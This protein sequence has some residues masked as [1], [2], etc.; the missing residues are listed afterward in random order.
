[1]IAK[2][3]T[4]APEDAMSDDDHPKVHT[5]AEWQPPN[6]DDP[7][8]YFDETRVLPE[9]VIGT[10]VDGGEWLYYAA[11]ICSFANI[12]HYKIEQ[13]HDGGILRTNRA[14]VKFLAKG[15]HTQVIVYTGPGAYEGFIDM[16]HQ[17]ET[18]SD[19]VRTMRHAA[20]GLTAE[21]VINRYYRSRAAG[22]KVTLQQLADEHGFNRSYLRAAK[23]EYDKAGKWGSKKKNVR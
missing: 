3:L 16:L 12:Q 6:P 10:Y 23:M 8:Y 4:R 21:E 5:A 20:S 13:T 7:D 22:G 9:Y 17:L 14:V 2:C 11:L 18:F 19:Q 15:P 1:M